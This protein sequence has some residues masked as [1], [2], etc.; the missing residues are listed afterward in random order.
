MNEHD[1]FYDYLRDNGCHHPRFVSLS[2]GGYYFYRSTEG[3]SAWNLPGG[4]GTRG[5]S[6]VWFGKDDSYVAQTEGGSLEWNLKGHYGSLGQTLKYNTKTIK[7]LGLN[8]TDGSSYLILFMDGS[9]QLNP[10]GCHLTT[11]EVREWVQSWI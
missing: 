7:T 3:S 8:V 2:P 5:F 11:A 1:G 4:L 9:I 10:G 6:H